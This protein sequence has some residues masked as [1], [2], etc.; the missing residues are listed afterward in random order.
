MFGSWKSTAPYER[1]LYSYEKIAPSDKKMDAPDKANA[2]F[3][4]GLRLPMSDGDADYPAMVLGNYMLGGG[5]LSS[6]LA[7]RIR[8]KDGLSY[9]VGSQ[10]TASE[11]EKNAS[12]RV[13]AISA[14]QN[15]AKVTA[16]ELKQA[17]S[18]WLQSRQLNRAEDA[19]LARSL[20]SH[21]Y[22]DRTLAWDASL[23]TKVGDLTSEQIDQAL[24]AN[25]KPDEISFVKA[26]DWK[27]AA[28]TTTK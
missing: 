28:E 15:V 3:L 10:F 13:Y 4:A 6:R 25:I 24:K 5:F 21:D 9:G 17:K 7:V 18:G 1:I 27:K 12:F 26:G 22:N 11:K 20:A 2:V 23:E 16:D 19:A 14:P 8:Q